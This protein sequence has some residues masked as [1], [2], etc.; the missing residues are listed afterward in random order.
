[1]ATSDGN[2][3]KGAPFGDAATPLVRNASVYNP[4]HTFEL[5]KGT[6]KNYAHQFADMYFLRLSLLKKAVKQ[7]AHEAWDDFELGGEKASFVERVLDVRQGQLCWVVGTVY[8]EMALKPNVL[9]DIS[10]EHWIVAPP[11]RETY[12]STS[13]QDEMML[14]DE[15]G[16]LR[17]TGESLSSH[18]VTGCVLAA[19]GTEQADG[20]FQVIATQYADL[21]RQPAR[22]ERDDAEQKTKPARQRAG[23]IAI[24]S[25]LEI[26]GTDDD[27]LALDLLVEYLTGEATGPP[28][29]TSSSQ[30]TRLIIAG[31]S[32][33]HSSPILSREAYAAKKGKKH[34]GYDASS[35]NASPAAR[36]DTLLS[37]L[38]P[39]L[40][41][42]LLPGASDPANVA[43]PQQPL[44]PA[45][46]PT[47]RLYTSAPNSSTPSSPPTLHTATNPWS[48]DIDGHRLL[49]TSGQPIA[50]LLKYVDDDISPLDAMEMT[51]RWR[52]IA[53]TAPDTLACYPFQDDDPL[54]VRECPHVYFAGGQAAFGT[55]VIRGGEGQSVVLVCVPR[56][57]E[58]GQVVVVDLE[59]GEVGVVEVGVLRPGE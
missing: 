39:T 3:L 51:L 55:R 2:M 15:S 9:D 4:L 44:H 5:P 53:P 58:G 30:I 33:S 35:Y 24:V 22:W 50:D 21:P 11:P 59:S 31:D 27:D 47:A 57:R 34:Y 6:E 52:C 40:P 37:T 18:Y 28:S 19:L 54:L 8:M 25:G 1:M 13:G 38:L 10:K 49:G 45:L 7:K 46:F 36:L 23:K 29:Q 32:L 26:T 16:R 17:V 20:S 42:T 43:L 56:F 41:I 48:A 12:V 14:E